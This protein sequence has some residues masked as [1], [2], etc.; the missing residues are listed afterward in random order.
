MA[1]EA[2]E[3]LRPALFRPFKMWRPRCG[4]F[5]NVRLHCQACLLPLCGK[6]H[7]MQNLEERL[8]VFIE[9][10]ALKDEPLGRNDFLIDTRHGIDGAV[11]GAHVNADC[12]AGTQAYLADGIRETLRTPPLPQ[13]LSIRPNFEY[14]LA[15]SI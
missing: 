2:V 11:W 1:I 14:E 4:R 9:R 10:R 12:A 15:R 13:L 8:A 3:A 5:E 6:G 7:G